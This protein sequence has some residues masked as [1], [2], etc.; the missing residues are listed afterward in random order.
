MKK[1]E[2]NNTILSETGKFFIDISKLVF[3][4]VILASIMKYE[5]IN[6]ALLLGIGCVAVV[7][8]FITGLVLIAMSKR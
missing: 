1:D 4:G 5:S 2:R 7:C 3:G 8:S 6:P